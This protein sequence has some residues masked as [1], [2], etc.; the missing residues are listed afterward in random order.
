[1]LASKVEIRDHVAAIKVIK[2]TLRA[3]ST[4]FIPDQAIDERGWRKPIIW[5]LLQPSSSTDTKELRDFTII[6]GQLYYR[7]NGGI[8]ARAILKDDANAELEYIHGSTCADNDISLYRR[9]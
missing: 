5:N 2:K 3:T 8:L 1:M 6:E 9:V 7:D 4:D